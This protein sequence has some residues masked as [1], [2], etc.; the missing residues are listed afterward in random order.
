MRRWTAHSYGRRYLITLLAIGAFCCGSCRRNDSPAKVS[1]EQQQEEKDPEPE[2]AE[3]R[4]Q[5]GAIWNKGEPLN[6]LASWYDVPDDSLAKRRA[7]GEEFTAAH[8]RL[9]I[10]TLVEVINP[11]NGK[12]VRV[13]VTDRGIHERKIQLD[14]CKEA[15]DRL[16]ILGKGLARVQMQVVVELTGVSSDG[17]PA[18]SSP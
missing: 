6:V 1:R 8:N 4:L 9:P 2:D 17:S 16:G 7:D 14:L 5:P 15:A 11:Q 3:P 13:R 18:A 12:K 10:G